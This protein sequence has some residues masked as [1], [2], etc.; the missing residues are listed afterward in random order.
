MFQDSISND[1]TFIVM[2]TC[3]QLVWQNVTYYILSL[4]QDW[5]WGIL[6]SK[7]IMPPHH[8]S[9]WSTNKQ[10]QC[11]FAQKK[12]HTH[13][14]T[15][16]HHQ[17]NKNSHTSDFSCHEM[18]IF[19]TFNIRA[20]S[21]CQEKHLWKI[22]S[23]YDLIPENIHNNAFGEKSHIYNKQNVQLPNFIWIQKTSQ[24]NIHCQHRCMKYTMFSDEVN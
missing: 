8:A 3:W 12:S 21:K 17:A 2:A 6:V 11:V 10:R 20:Q 13:D 19:V 7:A 23:I 5:A 24:S 22:N 14:Q 1:M 15:I 16:S 18:H 9:C 4:N